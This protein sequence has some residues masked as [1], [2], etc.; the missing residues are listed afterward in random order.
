MIW[1]NPRFKK[2]SVAVTE[3]SNPQHLVVDDIDIFDGTGKDVYESGRISVKDGRILA[4]GPKEAV[5]I[6]KESYIVD[7]KGMMAL[8]GMIDAHVHLSWNGVFEA[9]PVFF[10]EGLAERLSRNAWITLKSGVT[11]VREMPGFGGVKLKQSIEQGEVIG[12]RLLVSTSAL[13]V[14]G[15]Y[16]A[17]PLWGI[18]IKDTGKVPK[19]I[20]KKMKSGCDFIKTVAPHSDALRKEKNISS[21]LLSSIVREAKKFGLTVAAHTMWVDGLETAVDAGVTSLEHCPAYVGGIMPDDNF[22]KAKEKGTFFVPTADVLRRNYLLF[23]DKELILEE[24]AYHQNMPSKSL[25]KMLKMVAQIE[26]AQHEKPEARAAFDNLFHSY[27]EDYAVNFGKALEYDI[28]IAAGTDSG[29]NYTPHGILPKELELYVKFGMTTKQ[30]I[31]SA[32]KVGAELLGLEKEIGTLEPGKKADM[33]LVKGN[34]LKDITD[35]QKLDVVIKEGKI[36]YGS[37]DEKE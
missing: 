27:K 2:Q 35:L 28:K 34:P 30:A 18:A 31:L 29:V 24:E 1:N 26:K 10:G 25:A 20:E 6:P 5:E 3:D 21:A 22:A 37:S 13:T 15:G 19:I 36:V 8:P 7:G 14:K 33:I 16:F 9:Y 12:P 17:Y 4:I 11:T 32:T 23:N